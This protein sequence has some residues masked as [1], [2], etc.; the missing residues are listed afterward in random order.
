MALP[1]SVYKH[2]RG[3][4]RLSL[5]DFGALGSGRVRLLG[6]A[7]ELGVT[8]GTGAGPRHDDAALRNRR[9]LAAWR[10]YSAHVHVA[11]A[12]LGP[13]AGA[14]LGDCLAHFI[15]RLA[16]CRAA[17]LRAWFVDAEVALFTW[18]ILNT[19]LPEER[20]AFVAEQGGFG[21]PLSDEE[22]AELG[23]DLRA[24]AGTTTGSPRAH[25]FRIEFERVPAAVRERRALMRH[26]WAFVH[27]DDVVGAVAAAYRARLDR[28]LCLLAQTWPAFARAERERLFPLAVG[29]SVGWR[30]RGQ[31][32]GQGPGQGPGQGQ[33]SPPDP[34]VVLR[35]FA[36]FVRSRGHSDFKTKQLGPGIVA[37][38]QWTKANAADRSCPFARRVH[39]SNTVSYLVFLR[40]GVMV[41]RCWD[42]GCR[43]RTCR[44][45][46]RGG[47][48]VALVRRTSR[49][50]LACTRVPRATTEYFLLLQRE[51]R[52]LPARNWCTGLVGTYRRGRPGRPR[53]P[54]AAPRR[55]LH[56]RQWVLTCRTM[57]G[58]QYH[59]T[60]IAP[61]QV[62]GQRRAGQ[63]TRVSLVA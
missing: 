30:R 50:T 49:I 33:E 10:E 14:A 12:T 35:A 28:S 34:V 13:S 20:G 27:V 5:Q 6:A 22:F 48:V 59:A 62:P 46:L 42:S 38:G 58:T 39:K 55:A 18:R 7:H 52:A 54:T 8:G 31:G 45:A 63:V 3:F 23:L 29:L 51:S 1:L 56:S 44:F 17:D 36:Q 32:Q 53:R 4:D 57:H 25:Y 11:G 21:L 16:F 41:Q 24:A 43:G 15:G 47:R 40:D 9:M 19:M 37:L 61:R 60:V 26:G 2:V